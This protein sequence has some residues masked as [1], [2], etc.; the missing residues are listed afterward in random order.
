MICG[1]RLHQIRFHVLLFTAG[2][3]FF[4]FG[5]IFKKRKKRRAG[6]GQMHVGRTELPDVVAVDL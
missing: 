4:G 3:K 6:A 2:E 5:F 1:Q